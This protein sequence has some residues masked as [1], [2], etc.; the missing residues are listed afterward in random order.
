M[1][2]Y[3]ASIYNIIKINYSKIDLLLKR[4]KRCLKR[5]WK[6][7]KEIIPTIIVVIIVIACIVYIGIS[8]EKYKNV[9]DGLWDNKDLFLQSTIIVYFLNVINMEKQRKKNLKEQY[10]MYRIIENSIFDLCNSIEEIFSLAYLTKN[11][12]P[13]ISESEEKEYIDEL[14]KNMQKNPL[15]ISEIK[16]KVLVRLDIFESILQKNINKI[17]QMDIEQI[18]YNEYNFNNII[19]RIKLVKYKISEADNIESI[20]E[21]YKSLF[22]EERKV[23]RTISYT[24]SKDANTIYNL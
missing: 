8:T 17:E 5:M 6:Y 2:N 11:H 23:L 18:P 16:T 3:L 12:N 14:R 22:E 15:N 7:F 13:L 4:T 1:M 21:N 10:N 19:D 9:I 20:L 24:W